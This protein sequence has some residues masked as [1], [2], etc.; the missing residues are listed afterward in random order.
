MAKIEEL[1]LEY[2]ATE[3]QL[4]I[5]PMEFPDSKMPVIPQ[6]GPLGGAI[7]DPATSPWVV[8]ESKIETPADVEENIA[9]GD[10]D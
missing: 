4:L 3:P 7:L 1:S 5:V 10:N 2:G 8:P 9:T 6:A